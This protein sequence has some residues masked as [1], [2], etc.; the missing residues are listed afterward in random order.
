MKLTKFSTLSSVEAPAGYF[1]NSNNRKN[2]KREGA[3]LLS[4]PFPSFPA[5]SLFLSPQP[6][7]NTKRPPRRRENSARNRLVNCKR[8]NSH[9]LC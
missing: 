2:R 1:E 7:L 8:S 6:P 5:R 9:V 3:S 4:S